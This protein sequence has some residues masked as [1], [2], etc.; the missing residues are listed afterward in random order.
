MTA[1]LSNITEALVTDFIQTVQLNKNIDNRFIQS[2]NIQ[3]Q[4]SDGFYALYW[5]ISHHNIH[6]VKLL[7]AHGSTLKVTESK[8][9]LF[10][11]I[12]CDNLD[13]LKYFIEKGID[14]NITRTSITGQC[15]TL[16]QYAQKLKRKVIIEYL[17][18]ND[19]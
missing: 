11:A 4:D 1:P 8:N 19:Y 18:T 2:A 16:L 17:N 3:E 14:K 10:Y 5:A 6:N 15:H 13:A 7:I 9:A 12:D